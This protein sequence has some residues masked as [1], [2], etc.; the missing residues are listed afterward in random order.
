[1]KASV[2]I[3]INQRQ[4]IL[5]R[6]TCKHPKSQNQYIRNN[7]ILWFNIAMRYPQIVHILNGL[8]HLSNDTGSLHLINFSLFLLEFLIQSASLHVLKHYVKVS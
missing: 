1:M 8:H 3:R 5:N 7:D 4:L 6:I 2:T